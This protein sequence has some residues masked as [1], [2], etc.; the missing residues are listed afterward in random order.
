MIRTHKL[1]S[2]AVRKSTVVTTKNFT[3]CSVLGGRVNG[4]NVYT[5]SAAILTTQQSKRT[6]RF[7]VVPA[8]RLWLE[9]LQAFF[10][11]EPGRY[12]VRVAVEANA[13]VVA[14]KC[15]PPSTYALGRRAQREANLHTESTMN[16]RL[17][18]CDTQLLLSTLYVANFLD[19]QCSPTQWTEDAFCVDFRDSIV[20]DQLLH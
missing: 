1:C 16:S 11:G 20:F 15:S 7:H 5:F 4:R 19:V 3:E 8:S 2:L 18:D 10:L 6:E 9:L 13:A 12:K 17:C 14:R